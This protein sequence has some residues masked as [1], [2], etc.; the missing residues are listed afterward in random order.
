LLRPRLLR[1]HPAEL[2]LPVAQ[3]VGLHARDLADLA[4]AVVALLPRLG[5]VIA[6]RSALRDYARARS[7]TAIRHASPTLLCVEPEGSG[8]RARLGNGTRERLAPLPFRLF[9]QE[10]L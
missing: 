8:M 2:G 4:D 7:R 10:V 9:V 1:R 6:C 5:L 3:H